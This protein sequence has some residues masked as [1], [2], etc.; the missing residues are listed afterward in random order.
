MI[1]LLFVFGLAISIAYVFLIMSYLDGW[2][3]TEKIDLV[4]NDD[5]PSVSVVIAAFNEEKEIRACLDSIL[6]N[7]YPS[8]K[9]EII[10]VDNGSTDRTKEIVKEN[11][12]SQLILLE[13]PVG[14]KKEAL[15]KGFE[16]ASGK[17]ILCTDSD[18]VVPKGWIKSM[19][20]PFVQQQINFV[21][22][23]VKVGKYRNIVE[24]FQA[25]DMLAMMGVTA[26]GLKS[27]RT[28]LANG[29]NMA[30]AQSVY[31][32]IGEIPRK[33]IA[34]GDDLF[35][36][37]RFIEIDKDKVIFQKAENAIVSTMAVSGWGNLLQQR[38]RWASK[39]TSYV[40]SKDRYSAIFIYFF[41]MTI[42]GNILL[43]P[44]TAGFSLFIALFQLFIKGTID[45]AFL[46]QINL[47]FKQRHLLRYFI[48]SFF[49]HAAYIIFAGLSGLVGRPYQW[50]GR[51]AS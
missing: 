31:K 34:S 29:A 45:Y 3:E 49:V 30:F 36:L 13:E 43:I 21:L 4:Q 6:N 24:R 20:S 25:F 14:F 26:G 37:H 12:G 48:P 15:E 33:D 16:R 23:P 5:L 35:L 9:L 41:V 11:Y 44:A 27:D 7:A 28:Y 38:R 46:V 32:E 40:S 2:N 39:V 1:Y 47:F 17:L 22:G 51:E 19:V 42:A 8:E 50:R 10:V 18:C